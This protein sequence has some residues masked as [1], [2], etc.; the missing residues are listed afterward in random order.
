MVAV[1]SAITPGNE[2]L[3]YAYNIAIAGLILIFVAK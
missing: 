3:G 2:E 1:P